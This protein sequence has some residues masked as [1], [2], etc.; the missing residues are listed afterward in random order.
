[1]WSCICLVKLSQQDQKTRVAER[2][3]K[4][5]KSNLSNSSH[6]LWLV[7]ALQKNLTLKKKNN[8]P[9]VFA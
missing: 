6:F 3:K 7:Y 1:M 9:N 2:E 5:K 8:N 4:T